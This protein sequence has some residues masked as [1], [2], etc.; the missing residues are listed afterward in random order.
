[1]PVLSMFYGIVVYMYFF[2][3][4]KHRVPHVHVE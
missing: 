4:R 3:D 2:D 1:M